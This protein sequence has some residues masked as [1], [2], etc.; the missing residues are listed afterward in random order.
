MADN[1]TIRLT[2]V[3]M[4]HDDIGEVVAACR[5]HE[6]RHDESAAVHAL[7]RGEAQLELLD[8][9]DQARAGVAG[10][11]KEH[12]GIGDAG[13]AILVVLVGA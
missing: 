13:L 5:F 8:K 11:C 12:F 2:T 3:L 4:H 9:L 7:A 10:R 1:K 6:L